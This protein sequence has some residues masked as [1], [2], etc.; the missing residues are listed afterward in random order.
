MTNRG[1]SVLFLALTALLL[2]SQFQSAAAQ[3]NPA[4]VI[5][6]TCAGCRLNKLPKVKE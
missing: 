1:L 4:K 3:G 5:M 2:V 6:K